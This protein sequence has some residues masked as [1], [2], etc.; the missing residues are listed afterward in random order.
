MK[1][2]W[3]AGRADDG[4]FTLIEVLIALA[5]F[6]AAGVVF[7]VGVGA[8]VRSS[9]QHRKE[10]TIETLLRDQAE[11]LYATTA[12]TC[13]TA[14]ATI[15]YQPS[16]APGYRADQ[17]T[18]YDIT[19]ALGAGSPATSLTVPCSSFDGV[20]SGEHGEP[21][22]SSEPGYVTVDIAAQSHDGRSG[23]QSVAVVLRQ[24]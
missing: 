17:Y 1:G 19:F 23:S 4:G 21:P 15:N 3:G 7:V 18:S 2:K 6:A 22:P 10:A 12:A 5:I 24:P 8:A 20:P 16:D 9:D 14:G 11:G 13:A